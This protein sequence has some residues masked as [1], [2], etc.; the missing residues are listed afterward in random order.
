MLNWSEQVLTNGLTD[1]QLLMLQVSLNQAKCYFAIT[2]LCVKHHCNLIVSSHPVWQHLCFSSSLCTFSNNLERECARAGWGCAGGGCLCDFVQ[3]TP[4]LNLL[5]SKGSGGQKRPLTCDYPQ[6]F[7]FPS[8][9]LC[10][11]YC[12]SHVEGEWKEH[13]SAVVSSCD[14]LRWENNDVWVTH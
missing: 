12:R 5:D 14:E 13:I 7:L 1:F 10:A 9:W 11:I 2:I 8:V 4:S 6:P 3:K